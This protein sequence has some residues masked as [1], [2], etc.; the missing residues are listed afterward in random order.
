MSHPTSLK[1]TSSMVNEAT[2]TNQTTSPEAQPSIQ[3]EEG[4]IFGSLSDPLIEDEILKWPS[5]GHLILERLSNQF[6]D[7]VI[8]VSIG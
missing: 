8:F 4:K 6:R 2:T 1:L 3:G 5:L 7:T